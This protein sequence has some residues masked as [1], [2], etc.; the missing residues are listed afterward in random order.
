MAKTQAQWADFGWQG[1]R[2]RVPEDWNLGKVDGSPD[3]GYARLDDAE[4]VRAEV[5]WRTIR[6][7]ANE[8]VGALVDRYVEGLEK[9]AGKADLNFAVQ[10]RAK[11]LKD[12]RWLE[13]R[14][15]ETFTWEADFRAFNLALKAADGRILLLRLLGGRDEDL[16]EI[17]EEVM[18]SLED[19]FE[20]EQW[21]WSVYGLQFSMPTD[22][23]LESHELKSG[24][25]Q[26]SFEKG[27]QIC[28][29]QRLSLA[30]LLLKK[31]ELSDWYPVF[32]KKQLRDMDVEVAAEEVDGHPGLRMTGKPR[33]R[34]RQILRPLPWINPRPRQ[35]MDG[36]AWHCEATSKICIVEHL[37][38]KKDQRGD[39]TERIADGYLCH[40]EESTE[41]ESRGHAQLATRSQ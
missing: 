29:V 11:F 17:V 19:H 1:V 41:A 22:F 26:L 27:K 34:W 37:F 16:R 14:D 39:L 10:R 6:E 3:S 18:P 24:H 38:R 28:R 21:V 35:Y 30:Q 20:E 13:G 8:S 7:R 23:K 40:Q 15:Y 25:I 36:R 9:K 33:S 2:L 12:K 31:R 5:E 32:F 4:I